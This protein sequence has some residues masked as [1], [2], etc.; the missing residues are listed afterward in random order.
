MLIV[1][2]RYPIAGTNKSPAS[3]LPSLSLSSPK[4]Y[5]LYIYVL[6]ETSM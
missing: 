1:K 4:M 3:S 2:E 6:Y 5:T